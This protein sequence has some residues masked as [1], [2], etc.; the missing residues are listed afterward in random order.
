MKAFKV[1]ESPGADKSRYVELALHGYL[2]AHT[3][4]EFEACMEQSIAQGWLRYVIDVAELNYLSS[5]GIAAIISLT[6][7]L[8]RV[9][10]EVVLL[11]PSEKV[12]KILDKLGFTKI[13][14]LA[15]SR[16]EAEGMLGI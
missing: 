2:D 9:N 16:E 1:I 12:F 6:Q 10:G 11:R 5:A 3:V 4:G 15:N 13:F 8:R 14:C 7:R